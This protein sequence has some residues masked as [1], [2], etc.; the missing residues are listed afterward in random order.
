MRWKFLLLIAIIGIVAASGKTRRTGGGDKRVHL[1]HADLLHMDERIMPG[2]QILNGKVHFT[3]DGTILYCDSAYFYENTNSFRAFGHVRMIQGDTLTLTSDYAYYDG[4]DE[5]AIAR[6][7]VVLKNRNSTLYTDSLNYDRAYSIG[8]FFDG[9]KLVDKTNT[10]TADWGQYDTETHKAVFNYDVTLR[11][12]DTD[13]KTDTLYYD[14]GTGMAEMWGPTDIMQKDGSHIYTE[15]GFHNT[16]TEKSEFYD[17]TVI[18]SNDGKKLV[19]DSVY[20]DNKTGISRAYRNVIYVDEKNKNQLTGNYCY[21]EDKT[22]YAVATDNAVAIDYSQKD[23]MYIHADSFKLYTI[24]INTD[25]VYRRVHAYNHVRAYRNDVQAVCDSLVYNSKDSCVYMHK[26]PILWN[27]N[28]QLLGEEIRIYL[29]DS[30]VNWSHVIGQA[31]SVQQLKED[32]TCYNQIS[33]KEMKSFFTDGDL[34]ETQAIDN[35]LSIYYIIDDSD[36]TMIGCNCM[37][38]TQMK[39]FFDA[40]QLQKI[41]SPKSH[42]NVYPLNQ[43]PAGKSFLP[44]FAW[45]DF[46]RPL[47]KDDIFVWRGKGSD[48]VLKTVA[49]KSAPVHH[50]QSETNKNESEQD[51][52]NQ[53]IVETNL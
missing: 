28:Q 45:F 47:N 40:K 15:H 20:S 7:N 41:W 16:K 49:R 34:R 35:V 27:E 17:R 22:G 42:G 48:K 13:I 10:L 37:E 2:V 1:V 44:T 43:I 51:N 11:N 29:N 32:T 4:N 3:H 30:T 23:T 5:L 52:K 31:L 18:S 14:V 46:I 19:G 8:Y 26:D 25:S 6:H 33:S 9:G 53:E 39:M 50:L 38:T 36:T 24:N 21:Y 12:K